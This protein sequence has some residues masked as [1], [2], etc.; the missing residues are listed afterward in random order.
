MSGRGKQASKVPAKAK[1]LSSRAGLQFPVG[2]V[3]RLL[4]KCNYSKWVGAGTPVYLATLLSTWLPRSWSWQ[5]TLPAKTNKKTRIKP[6]HLHLAI[7][8]DEELNKLLR[9]DTIAQAGVL[10]VPHPGS[11]ATE[12]ECRWYLLGSQISMWIEF[13]MTNSQHIYRLKAAF[14][15]NSTKL[16]KPD[17][18][19]K[20]T[21]YRHSH[22]ENFMVTKYKAGFHS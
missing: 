6:R 22:E 7:R 11:A 3:H 9:K 21:F 2:G 12:E 16:W 15:R 19:Q 1:T 13:S 17:I 20:R 5:V 4:R 10:S 8:N 18:P 14:F